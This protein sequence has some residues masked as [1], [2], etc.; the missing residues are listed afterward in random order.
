MAT[1]D[2]TGATTAPDI[3]LPE[4]QTR[5][6]AAHDE[7]RGDVASPTSWRDRVRWGPIWGGT[8]TVLP[9]FV[10][11]QLLFFALGWLDLG[12]D[13][14]NAGTAR[15]VVSGVLA[16]VAF[17]IGGLLAGASTMWHGAPDGTLHGILVWALSVLGILA[18]GM[19][20][21][22][23]LLGPLA[24]FAGQAAA[25]PPNVDAA[26]AVAIGRE[27]AGWTA[28]GLG[29]SAVAAALGGT[30]GSKMWPGRKQ[31]ARAR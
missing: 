11:L 13:A 8:V 23:A 5:T 14:A 28:L 26:Q 19:I 9:V 21:G 7:M 2:N 4:Q 3:T 25:S 20:G 29:L 16:L 30:V 22:S 10:V 15:A 6:T 1:R 12:A 31:S 18:L 17:F 27:A 24:D